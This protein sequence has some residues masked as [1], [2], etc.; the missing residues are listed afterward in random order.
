V[1]AQLK[2]RKQPPETGLPAVHHDVAADRSREI[3][4][5]DEAVVFP[6]VTFVVNKHSSLAINQ[7]L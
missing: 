4:D 1:P 6:R 3:R 2:V 5:V 7:I